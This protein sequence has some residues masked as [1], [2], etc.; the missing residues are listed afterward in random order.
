MYNTPATWIAAHEQCQKDGGLLFH[1]STEARLNYFKSIMNAFNVY[2][3]GGYKQNGNWIWTT[4]A[5]MST[6][7]TNMVA[8]VSPGLCLTVNGS[9]TWQWDA[10]DCD[11]DLHK[12]LCEISVFST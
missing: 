11:V 4:G 9:G 7:F 10:V 3:I 6:G 2:H 12:F 8:T 5:L 1:F